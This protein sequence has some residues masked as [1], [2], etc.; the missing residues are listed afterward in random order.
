M[1]GADRSIRRS[2]VC[3]ISLA[4]VEPDFRQLTMEHRGVAL[5]TFRIEENFSIPICFKI[6]VSPECKFLSMRMFRLTQ[7]PFQI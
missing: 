4:N 5:S 1:S 3:T 2:Y 6:F 7:H